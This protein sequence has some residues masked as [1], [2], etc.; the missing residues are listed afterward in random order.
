MFSTAFSILVMEHIVPTIRNPDKGLYRDLIRIAHIKSLSA[1]ITP[2]ILRY[3][4]LRHTYNQ[5]PVLAVIT[6]APQHL[7]YHVHA[8]RSLS[9]TD[10]KQLAV[11]PECYGYHPDLQLFS[12]LI[13]C[14]LASCSSSTR[15][16]GV[17]H[18]ISSR[19]ASMSSSSSLCRIA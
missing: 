2:V 4:T 7:V 14:L 5:S 6:E 18:P 19:T 16:I 13:S 11:C 17:S 1:H 15:E 12:F 3:L 8:V 9:A 10:A